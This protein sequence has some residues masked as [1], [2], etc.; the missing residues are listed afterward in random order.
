[1]TAYAGHGGDFD[2]VTNINLGFLTNAIGAITQLCPNLEFW[3]LQSGGK[4]Y[5]WEFL[6]QDG[7]PW[8]VPLKESS[9]PVPEPFASKIFYNAQHQE[10][11]RQSQGK[12]WTFCEVMPD[13]MSGHTPHDNAMGNARALCRS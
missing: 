13:I 8:K 2:Q 11:A 9:L 12:R 6:G 10:L 3:S 1:M 7:M 4:A 5:G